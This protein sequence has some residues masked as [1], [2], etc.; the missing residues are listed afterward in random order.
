[1]SGKS[2]SRVRSLA[3]AWVGA[4]AVALGWGGPGAAY[5][6]LVS[7]RMDLSANLANNILLMTFV[8]LAFAL[9]GVML[10]ALRGAIR[11]VL[12]GIQRKARERTDERTFP[13]RVVAAGGGFALCFAILLCIGDVI[14]SLAFQPETPRWWLATR[15]GL[16]LGFGILS[17]W[18][19]IGPA[20]RRIATSL[21][22]LGGLRGLW[23]C[24]GLPVV[25]F[26]LALVATAFGSGSG[27]SEDIPNRPAAFEVEPTGLKVVLIGA[28][29]ATWT[30]VDQ[31]IEEGKLPVIAGLAERGAKGTPLSPA[32]RASPITWT[33]IV[34]GQPKERHGIAEYLLV[35]LPSVDPFPFESLAHDPSVLPFSFVVLGYFAAGLADGFPPTSDRVLVK[36][37]WH[38][39]ADGGFRSLVLGLP[40]TWPA[41]EIPG[42][43]VTDRFGPN[44][45]DMFSHQRGPLPGRIHPPEAEARLGPLVVDS[46]GDPT[47]MLRKLG[48]FDTAQIEELAGWVYNPIIA[49]PLG[50][51]TDVYD[52]D[53]TFLNI[54]Q[55]EMGHGD[56]TFAAVLINGLDLAM[57]AFW[58]QRFPEDFGLTESSH[59][60]WG[61]LI[62]AYHAELDRRLGRLIEAI[63]PEAVILLLSDSGMEASRGN[64]V[65]PGWHAERALLLASGGP[66]RKGIRLETVSYLDVVPTILYLLGFPIPK[67][68]PGRV[69]EE[70]IVP[71]FLQTHPPRS[72]PS[73]E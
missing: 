31:L 41:Q 8:G 12:S 66:I 70:M 4:L 55:E 44:E 22:R 1:M 68:L 26:C 40:C 7:I 51:L 64:L 57:H 20:A 6:V 58:A 45:F 48:D 37:I 46:A 60:A 35:Q 63:G 36:S 59:P 50:M 32:P 43:M 54:L 34:T 56:Y 13:T 16:A 72:I 23:V 10:F 19:L 71:E 5:G 9:L 27:R 42:L 17:A 69:L 25:F 14:L 18:F 28:D 3:N 73:Y 33:T 24:L 39:L 49:S 38:M 65:W 11:L 62:D 52:A 21:P 67:D 2:Q 53:M 47:P 29:G 15:V 30:V 61:L